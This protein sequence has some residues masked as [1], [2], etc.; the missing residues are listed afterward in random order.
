MMKYYVSTFL[1]CALLHTGFAQSIS[2]CEG[3]IILCDDFYSEEAASLNTGSVYEFTGNC[4]QFLEQSSVWYSFTVQSSGELSFVLSPNN[5]NDDYDWGLFNISNG[6]CAGIGTASSPEVSCNSWGTLFPP[7]GAT[8]ISSANGGTGNSNGPGDLNGP[9]FNAD[10][11]VQEGQVYALVVM[12]W[13]NSFDGY[14]INFGQSTASLYDDIPPS[15]VFADADCANTEIILDFSENILLSSVQDAD[16]EV[17]GP[18]GTILIDDVSPENLGAQEDDTFILSLASQITEAGTYT[19]TVTNIS[20]LVEDGCGNLGEGSIEIILAEPL[21]FSTSTETACNG[22]GGSFEIIDITG[23]VAPFDCFVDGNPLPDCMQEDSGPGT[24][25]VSVV[26][27]TGCAASLDLEVPDH[28]IA[29]SIGLQDSLSCL[30][31]SIN[32]EN[33]TIVPEQSVNYSFTESS[34]GANIVSGANTSS[35]AINQPGTYELVITDPGSG[36]TAQTSFVVVTG[37]VF[38]VDLSD[39]IFPNVISPNGDK[40][41]DYWSIYKESDPEFDLGGVLD[42]FSLVV[43]NRWGNEVYTSNDVNAKW[44]ASELSPGVYN[45]IVTY[46]TSCGSEVKEDKLLT[47]QIVK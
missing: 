45:L 37:E 4:N 26:D 28:D 38:G 13:S 15:P 18:G 43:Y 42:S 16:F 23:G 30:N 1:F 40:I 29:V 2:D 44:D 12:N 19:I 5:P 17:S 24:F 39:I 25:T 35:P 36:C 47:L 32:V 34:E 31:P 11:I 20:G 8:G 7:N 21:T 14:S 10:L 9:P 46:S 3:A 33:I 27:S 6:G 41:N 22:V